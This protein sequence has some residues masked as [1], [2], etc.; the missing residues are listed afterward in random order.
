LFRKAMTHRQ[1]ATVQ[2]LAH[3][4]HIRMNDQMPFI[5]LWQLDTHIAIHR[6]LQIPGNIDPLLIFNDVENWKLQDKE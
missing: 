2:D 1:F 4:I 3:Q 6:S 5:P